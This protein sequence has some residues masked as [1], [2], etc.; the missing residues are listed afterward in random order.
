MNP[1]T[2]I[3]RRM[4]VPEIVGMLAITDSGSFEVVGV[5]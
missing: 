1:E 5:G 3:W 2:E 4:P